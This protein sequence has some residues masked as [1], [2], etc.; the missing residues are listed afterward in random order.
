MTARCLVSGNE[1]D[2]IAWNV[3]PFHVDWASE[4]YHRSLYIM[5]FEYSLVLNHLNKPGIRLAL[6]GNA[7]CLDILENSLYFNSMENTLRRQQTVQVFLQLVIV[8]NLVE[9]Y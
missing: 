3:Y 6:P 9:Q 8:H 2:V 7:P 1:M 5:K 4:P